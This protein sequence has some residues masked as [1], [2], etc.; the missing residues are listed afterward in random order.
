[1]DA[2]TQADLIASSPLAWVALSGFV[3]ENQAP[4]E[5]TKHRFMIDLYSDLHDDIVCIKSAQVGFSV[6]AILSSFHELKYQKRNILYVLPTREIVQSFVVPKVNP[7]IESNPII[8]REVKA[9][10]VALKQMGDRYIYFKGGFSEREAISI[11]VDTLIVDEFDRMPDMQIVNMFDSRLQ[12]APEPKRKRFSNP[13]GVGF[14]V[15]ALY[16]DSDQRHWFIKCDFCTYEWYLDLEP[17]SNKNHYIDRTR[18][19]FVCGKCHKPLSP[20]ARRLGRWVQK[21]PSKDYRHGYWMSQLMAPWVTAKRILTQEQ[22]MDV[23]TFMS[24]VLGKAFTPTDLIV[25]RETILRA[26][27]PSQ[28]QPVGVA[29]GVDQ[30]AQELHYVLMTAQGMFKHGK[31]RSWEEIE[32]IKLKYQATVV[33]DAMPYPTMPKQLAA[34]YQD[35]Y[36]CYFRASTKMDIV[37]WKHSVVYADR[38]RLLDTVAQEI[39]EA[40]LLF[41]ER[42]ME[43]EDYILDWSNLYRTTEEEDDGRIKITWMKKAGHESDYSFATAYARIALSK[44]LSQ[45]IGQV[46]EGGYQTDTVVGAMAEAGSLGE[47]VQLT[48]DGLE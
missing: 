8:S 44:L 16:T 33:A 20:D 35:F 34:K 32:T 25:N 9:D 41:R 7:L 12:A 22:E 3:N 1:M 17:S 18:G 29:M 2:Q 15:D 23:Q 47:S 30:K 24:F 19:E 48:L 6:F 46:V 14:G 45:G 28:I 10:A 21:Y 37:Q 26:C 5:F 11:S 13:S 39:S 38:T 27:S 43:L 31:V 36:M 42:P 4:M 40:K